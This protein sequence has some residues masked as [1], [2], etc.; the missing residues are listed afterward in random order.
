MRHLIFFIWYFIVITPACAQEASDAQVSASTWEKDI[1]LQRFAVENAL[2]DPRDSS[3]IAV[4]LIRLGDLY[5][6]FE[7]Y[8]EAMANY[9]IARTYLNPNTPD[10]LSIHLYNSIAAVEIG[11]EDFDSA[12]S[13]L[14]E[15]ML[16]ADID[17]DKKGK[18]LAYGLLGICAEKKGDYLLA[19][20]YQ[21]Q[22]LQLYQ[23]MQ[24]SLGEAMTE[25]NIG[26]IYED[27]EQYDLAFEHFKKSFAYLETKPISQT[28]NLLN[29][30]GDVRRKQG[31]LREGLDYTEQ[32]LK[33]AS[34]LGD[35]HQME[36]AHKDLSKG[37]AALGDYPMAYTHLQQADNFRNEALKAQNARQLNVLRTLYETDK[38]ESEIQLL[39]E[40]NKVQSANQ[41]VLG[42]AAG[43]MVL[44][45]VTLAVLA[46]YRG[47]AEK[48][49][50][51]LREQNLRA[52]YQRVSREE[53]DLQREV[54]HKSVAL[55][56][57]SLNLSHKNKL[58]MDL[59]RFLSHMASRNH[60]DYS[61]KVRS[62]VQEIEHSLTQDNEWDEFM[63][64][65]EEIHP[66]F[67]KKLN[68]LAKETL[69][70]SELRLGMLLRMNLSSKEIASILR[71]TPDSVRVARYRLRK[72]LPIEPKKELVNFMVEL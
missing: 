3:G 40:Q 4:Q 57:Y 12:R 68:N 44:L 42:V 6:H 58:L 53:A 48:K 34:K 38:K 46:V 1:V 63:H 20:D 33:L 8:S 23:A 39:R 30:L 54:K 26:S 51:V 5:T 61:G 43:G 24:D 66:D 56:R 14:E 67:M 19:L 69:S 2:K 64:I 16:I 22:S 25:E 50:Q 7:L 71:V 13:L 35:L 72:K 49:M 59:S 21:M 29:N 18:A 36:S 27:L 10:T 60:L 65:F 32:A 31:R 70:P 15:V 55:T 17:R 62:W 45:F 52:E 11:L 28:A 9:R 47:R 41:R 37:Y